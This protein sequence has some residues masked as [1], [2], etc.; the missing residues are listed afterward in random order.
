VGLVLAGIPEFPPSDIATGLKVVSAN[1]NAYSDTEDS[2]P[3]EA[4]LS[5]LKAGVLI[6]IE[7]RAHNVVGMTRVADNYEEDLPR[8][9]HGTA[10]FCRDPVQCDARITEEFGSDHSR[11]PLA[12]VRLTHG[13]QRPIC[14][15]GIHSP[16]PA[17]FDTSG[18]G[19]YISTIAS[20]L[21]DG[22]ISTPWNPCQRGDDAVVLG[23]MNAV[24][25][26]TA[27]RA[28]RATGL[29][30]VLRWRGI[31]ASSWPAGGGWPNLPLLR[32]DHLLV[33]TTD[34]QGVHLQRIPGSDHKALVAWLK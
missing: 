10:V 22:S 27:W 24:P 23:D 30:D 29:T 21:E 4:A 34:A 33:G 2:A 9:S 3:L 17:P 25:W 11:M 8:I 1:V 32:L 20:H 16:P 26:S 18:I 6:T 19:P 7:E 12:L 5:E 15:L 31:Y 14:L 13:V 28:L